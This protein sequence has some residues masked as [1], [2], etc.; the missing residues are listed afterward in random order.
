MK[1]VIMI[2]SLL[3]VLTGCG[4]G[5][6][7]YKNPSE[8]FSNMYTVG[9]YED[10]K[11][12]T[13]AIDL[14]NSPIADEK[15][16]I[17]EDGESIMLTYQKDNVMFNSEHSSYQDY[18]FS[19]GTNDNNG[20]YELTHYNPDYPELYTEATDELSNYKFTY[21]DSPIDVEISEV[22]FSMYQV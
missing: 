10:G 1:Y 20:F 7:E 11:L 18:Y 4:G 22:D 2:I 17:Y 9:S 8:I 19:D 12:S 14:L 3:I 15:V 13:E 5:E 21:N 16:H 6:I